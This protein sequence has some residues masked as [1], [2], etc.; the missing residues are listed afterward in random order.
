MVRIANALPYV[1]FYSYTNSVKLV[2][3]NKHLQPYNFSFIFSDSGK[4]VDLINKDTDRYTRIFKSETELT[5]AGFVNA[6]KVD[7]FA[8]SHYNRNNNKIG[9]IYH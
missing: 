1:R 8:S 2:K 5:K 4:Q 3:D 7:L 6:S 9:L